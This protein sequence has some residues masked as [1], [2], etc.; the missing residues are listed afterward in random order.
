MKDLK[1]QYSKSAETS[2]TGYCDASW[3]TDSDYPKS[4]SGY[5]FMLQGGVVSWNCRRQATLAMSST[6][7]EY[8]SLSA[9]TQEALWLNRLAAEH[10]IVPKDMPLTIYCDNKGAIDLSKNS[11]FSARTKQINVRDYFIKESIE[12]GEIEVTF[13]PATH[14]L[15]DSLTKAVNRNKLQ[16][17]INTAGL[18]NSNKKRR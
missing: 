12:R 6:E 11:R 2:L 8:L 10:L 4:K 17:F 3:T 13:V 14:M 5:I 9:A 16:G 7:A 18:K 15:A 1:L